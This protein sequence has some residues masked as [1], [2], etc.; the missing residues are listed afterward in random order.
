MAKLGSAEA[1][2]RDTKSL[3][4]T[5]RAEGIECLPADAH[6]ATIRRGVRSITPD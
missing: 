5:L 6:F 2:L 3:Q 4:I 1:L